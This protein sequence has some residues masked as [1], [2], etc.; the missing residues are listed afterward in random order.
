MFMGVPI[1]AVVCALLKNQIKR[2]L[3]AKNLPTELSEYYSP[4]SL[5]APEV[6]EQEHQPSKIFRFGGW[7]LKKEE[8]VIA[9][10]L[11]TLFRG[12]KKNDKKSCDTSD[13]DNAD[14]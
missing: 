12:K 10:K 14:Q 11:R 4:N 1:F 8:R 7:L 5:V 2:R 9:G 13:T 3:E 6:E